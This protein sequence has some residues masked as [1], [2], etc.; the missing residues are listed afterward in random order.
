MKELTSNQIFLDKLAEKGIVEPTAVQKQVVPEIKSGKNILFQSETGTGK[1]LAYL[2]PLLENISQEEKKVQIVISAPT[3][4]L[5]SQIKSEI[6]SISDIKVALLIGGAPIKRQQELLKEKPLVVIGG[7]VRLLELINLKKLKVDAVK[8]IVLD[9]VDRLLSPELRDETTELVSS[10]PKNS[11]LISCSATTKSNI[12]KIVEDSLENRKSQN[13]PECE[14]NETRDEKI[15]TILL[16]MED[17]LKRK[18]THWAFFVEQRKKIE[19]LRKLLVAEKPSKV[20]IFTSRADQVE[21]I[22]SKLKFAKVD[23]AALHAKTDKIE[24]KQAIDRFRSGKNKILITSDLAARGLDFPDVS[25]I[26]QMD[27]STNDDFFIHRA[28]RTARAGKTGINIVIG[29]AHEMRLYA[30]LEKKLGF[31][32]YP[33]ELHNGKVTEP[34][35]EE[36]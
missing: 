1:T 29:D 24:R 17:V 11:N 27:V 36:R 3:H 6:Q 20:L 12:V 35:L 5:A 10:M 32:V 31:V 28:G 26:I 23:C 21:N 8:A 16:P 25:H 7:P 19:F 14:N 15:E 30:K 4:E 22:Y 2:I 34:F 9:E 18:I 33:K 13:L